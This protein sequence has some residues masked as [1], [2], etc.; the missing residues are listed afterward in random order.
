MFA[1][2][3]VL[4]SVSL[5]QWLDQP[6]RGRRSNPSA[7]RNVARLFAA[8]RSCQLPIVH[9]RHD[10]L[11]LGSTCRAGQPGHDF[12]VEAAPLAGEPVIGKQAHS[13]FIATGLEQLL[14]SRGCSTLLIVGAG[15]ALESTVRMSADLG[16]RT[17]LPGDATFTFEKQDWSGRVRTAAEVH[18]MSLANLSDEYCTIVTSAWILAQLASVPQAAQHAAVA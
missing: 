6:A 11:E 9:V 18:D 4:L 14:R 16:F 15:N 17:Y 1:R 13:A 10:S 12:K 2:D 5:Q 8:W 7:E 3:A